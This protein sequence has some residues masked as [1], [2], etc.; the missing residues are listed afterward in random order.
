MRKYKKR[1]IQNVVL[2]FVSVIV[3]LLLLEL[4]TRVLGL[5]SDYGYPEDMYQKDELLDYSLTPNIEGR[6]IK[7]EFNTPFKTNSKGM[8]DIEY[9]NKGINDYRILSLGDSFIW[10]M[11]GTELSET[12][13]KILESNLN[14]E[15]ESTNFQVMNSGVPG[16][17]TDQEFLYLKH[18]TTEL[19]LDMVILSFTIG[20]DF[21]DNLQ[22]GEY[23]VND[24]GQLIRQKKDVPKLL[25]IRDFML[26]NS[27]S[28]RLI[29]KGIITI[30][31]KF[32]GRNVVGKVRNFDLSLEF[33][34]VD[35]PKKTL[36]KMNITTNLL[37]EINDFTKSKNISL[38]LVMI[39]TASQVD[40]HLWN[41]YIKENKLDQTKYYYRKSQDFLIKWA[42][43]N[44]VM[45][46]DLLPSLKEKNIDNDFYWS[47]N[48][49]FN[50]KGNQETANI[51]YYNL[52]QD[53]SM[54]ELLEN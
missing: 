19:E 40:N 17:G 4:G 37:K 26:E 54:I 13:S 38:V 42:E 7:Q 32:I 14:E 35:P 27:H 33:S 18:R 44:N 22:N 52:I 20:N 45:I 30:F 9:S 1:I 12:F 2:L 46:I 47:L 8:N 50:K 51:L 16:Y 43:H 48:A 6:V 31:Y 28:Y 10:G 24:H 29:E 11:Y 21:Y 3:A 34:L 41:V 25:K 23:T 5:N 53:E 15:S 39:P 36:D 49:H